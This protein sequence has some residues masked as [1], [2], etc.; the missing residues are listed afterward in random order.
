MSGHKLIADAVIISVFI[1]YVY[2]FIVSFSDEIFF[3]YFWFLNLLNEY[4][5]FDS[6]SSSSRGVTAPQTVYSISMWD[7]CR[8]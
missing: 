2:N 5:P 1:L 4:F 6:Y 7:V 3:V 8:A